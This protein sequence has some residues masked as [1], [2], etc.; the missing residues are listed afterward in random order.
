MPVTSPSDVREMLL[1]A[2]EHLRKAHFGSLQLQ[3]IINHISSSVSNPSPDY[4]RMVLTELHELFRTGCLAWG[5]NFA[6][7]SPPL[8][9][10]TERGARALE[11]LS[12][13]PANPEGYKQHLKTVAQL[14]PVAESYLSEAL[15]CFAAGHFKASAVMLGTASES[16]ILELRDAVTNGLK[17]IGSTVPKGLT[18]WMIK[19]VLD[20]VQKT[21][22]AH[23][24][25]LPKTLKEESDAHWAAFTYQIR[26]TRNDAG[27]PTSVDPVSEDDVH[28]MFLI[29]PTMARLTV[30]LSSFAKSGFK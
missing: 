7:P 21:I 8:F 12:R 1:E 6:N 10:V 18:A 25:A 5:L 17:T 2:I 4:Q 26:K 15:D 23:S 13:D 22:N 11:N 20:E 14:N 29:F 27:H 3:S 16:L 30:K 28:G 9:H 24:S 19:T